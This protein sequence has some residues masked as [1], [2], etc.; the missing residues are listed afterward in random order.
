MTRAMQ[1]QRALLRGTVSGE[2]KDSDGKAHHPRRTLSSESLER[3]LFDC[4]CVR[5]CTRTHACVRTNKRE[6]GVFGGGGEMALVLS[7]SPPSSLADVTARD[8]EGEAARSRDWSD[9]RA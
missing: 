2:L 3:L 4:T 6:R 7:P 8:S 5:A 1:K 9:V